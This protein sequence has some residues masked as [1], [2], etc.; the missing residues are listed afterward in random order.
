MN[1]NVNEKN[2]AR[3]LL[4][5]I[6]F[7]DTNKIEKV[8]AE[9][10]TRFGVVEISRTTR[11]IRNRK[12]KVYKYNEVVKRKFSYQKCI[13]VLKFEIDFR[14]NSKSFRQK[15]LYTSLISATE[16]SSFVF[17]KASYSI[18]KT[19][20]IEKSLTNFSKYYGSQ[21]H[22]NLK[23]IRKKTYF[24]FKDMY[25]DNFSDFQRKFLSKIYNC[26]KIFVGHTDSN[27]VFKNIEKAY[28]GQPD[29][30]F[31]DPN[32]DYFVV[33]EKFHLRRAIEKI[34]ESSLSRNLDFHQSYIVQLQS[35][36]H[37]I[38]EYD[39]KYGVL[40]NWY[41]TI[42][43]EEIII[44]DFTFKVIHKKRNIDL[45]EQSLEQIKKLKH[46]GETDFYN[47]VNINKCLKCSVNLYC[48]HKTDKYNTLKYPY[49]LDYVKLTYLTYPQ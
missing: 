7:T 29:Y 48:G 4:M 11:G 28:V 10:E 2:Y 5:R 18:S 15:E 42:T 34:S 24:G 44:D 30:I 20:V 31:R 14:F 32:G 39:L 37:Y 35:Y 23:L 43:N 25:Q 19:Y 46:L 12:G 41:Y 8:L 40:L 26:E 6:G 21:L 47:N 13:S 17:C 22:E 9:Y 33:E 36:I 16:I 1:S 27:S 3:F 38:K 45:L 49:N